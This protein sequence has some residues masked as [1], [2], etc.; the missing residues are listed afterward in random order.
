MCMCVVTVLCQFLYKLLSLCLSVCLSHTHAHTVSIV[1]IS[2]NTQLYAGGSGLFT[3]VATG[4]P[5]P[6]ITW[7]VNGEDLLESD[8]IKV[9]VQFEESGGVTFVKSIL[10]VCDAQT[11]DAAE[12]V[13]VAE[14]PRLNDTASF[15]L[16]VLTMAPT[17][18]IPP[19][20]RTIVNGTVIGLECQATGAP[21]PS[22]VWTVDGD[23]IESGVQM[24][25][26]S[27]ITVYSTVF[28]GAVTASADYVCNATNDLG[29]DSATASVT[30]QCMCVCVLHL[31]IP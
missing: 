30:V 8:R 10:E 11:R 23:V 28:L 20:D 27:V 4:T 15:N 26:M 2:N 9:T 16:D 19:A 3:C 24:V 12:Y 14:V 13:C 25:S 1:M 29:S 18:E 31:H 5:D 6:Y 22:I 7:Q 17:I 21:R